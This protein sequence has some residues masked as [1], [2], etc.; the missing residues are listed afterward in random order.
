MKT[1]DFN[2][3]SSD[4]SVTACRRMNNKSLLLQKYLHFDKNKVLIIFQCD[5]FVV[6]RWVDLMKSKLKM[7]L[8]VKSK[9]FHGK[10]HLQ[11]KVIKNLLI[12]LST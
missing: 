4:L 8:N 11:L 12:G 10:N 2:S 6:K 7:K 1:K 5:E 9:L 3:F